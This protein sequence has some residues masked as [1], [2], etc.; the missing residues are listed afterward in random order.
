MINYWRKCFKNYANF[1]GR[2]RRKE[3]WYYA[4]FNAIVSSLLMLPTL[5]GLGDSALTEL[6]P[7]GFILSG[8][9]FLATFIPTIAVLAR[10]LH[11]IGKNAR[12]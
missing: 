12:E 6:I 4:L 5:I 11:D 10:R 2:A 7:V 8:L 3:Y 1:N 9:Y